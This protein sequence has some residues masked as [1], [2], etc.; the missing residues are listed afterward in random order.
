MDENTTKPPT[1]VC[2]PQGFEAMKPMGQSFEG[3]PLQGRT[4]FDPHKLSSYPPM[5]MYI[6]SLDPPPAEGHDS[7]RYAFERIRSHIAITGADAFFEAY[8][9]WWEEKGYWKGEDPLGGA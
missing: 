9:K 6:E 8:L 1:Q 4:K 2:A 3:T 5:Q 7:H